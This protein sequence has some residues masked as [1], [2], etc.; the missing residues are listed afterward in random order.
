MPSVARMTYTPLKTPASKMIAICS[1]SRGKRRRPASMTPFVPIVDRLYSLDE[2]RE[3]RRAMLRYA[4][5]FPP[6]AE[7]NQH[8]QI[9]VSLRRL[10][11]NQ[12][13]LDAHT[14]EAPQL[15]SMLVSRSA[16]T[17]WRLR[18]PAFFSRDRAAST[19]YRQ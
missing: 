1:R 19:S 4:R 3:L 10:F 6:G 9:A 11:R 18:R 5:Y 14:I 2:L 13:W 12:K 7:R 17:R 15:T 8:L 16:F